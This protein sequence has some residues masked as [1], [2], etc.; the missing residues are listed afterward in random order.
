M[1]LINAIMIK[2]RIILMLII[3]LKNISTFNTLKFI[4]AY[5]FLGDK[6]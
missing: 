3:K 4:Y 2:L 1:W 5:F 6:V